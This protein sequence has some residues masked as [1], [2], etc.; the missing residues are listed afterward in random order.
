MD[1][2]QR[3]NE[4]VGILARR[5]ASKGHHFIHTNMNYNCNGLE[6]E[7]DILTLKGDTLYFY[8][9]KLRDGYCQRQ[10]ALSQFERFKEA[11]EHLNIRGVYVANGYDGD[12]VVKRLN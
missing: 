5:L 3:H 10:K 8:E 2:L 1:D 11:Y 6:G 12:L 7:V 9:Y 4:H